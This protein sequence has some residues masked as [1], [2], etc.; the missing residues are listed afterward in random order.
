MMMKEAFR[1]FLFALLFVCFGG[2]AFAAPMSSPANPST[3]TD[4]VLPVPSVIIYPGDMI[5]D[6]YL[7]D[8]DFSSDALMPRSGVINSRLALVG[9]LARRTLLP[10]VPIPLNAVGEPNAIANGSRVRVVFQQEGLEIETYAVA[11]QAGSVG[12]V[13]SVRNP[14]SGVTISGVIQA[15]GSV[16]VGG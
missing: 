1:S 10:G 4:S 11:L 8:R 7:V 2:A 14:E 15:D 6:G 12:Q 9:K 16:L 5:Q 13:I 3:A